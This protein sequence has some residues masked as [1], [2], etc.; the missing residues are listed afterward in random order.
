MTAVCFKIAAFFI[1]SLG[2]GTGEWR[3]P[4]G[5][6]GKLVNELIRVCSETGNGPSL[7]AKELR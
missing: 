5:G 1:T 4:K 6:M 3:V 2:G 7:Q